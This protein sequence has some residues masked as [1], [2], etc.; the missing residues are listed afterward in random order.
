MRGAQPQEPAT[1]SLS[2]SRP[3]LATDAPV[4]TCGGFCGHAKMCFSRCTVDFCSAPNNRLLSA[5]W[6]TE[7]AT[8]R[9]PLGLAEE[10]LKPYAC[11]NCVDFK[12]H[13]LYLA[14][15]LPAIS[16]RRCDLSVAFVAA[17]CSTKKALPCFWATHGRY[18]FSSYS[19]VLR[20]CFRSSCF[21]LSGLIFFLVVEE[22]NMLQMENVEL[23]SRGKAFF[24]RFGSN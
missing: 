14:I 13:N 17:A 22:I 12:G 24:T 10:P 21:S 2:A 15:S 19:I 20:C 5:P 3:I 18:K 9:K 4:C 11:S 8:S 23:S 6:A 7:T 1:K 16:S